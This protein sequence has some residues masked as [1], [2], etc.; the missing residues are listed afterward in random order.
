M[1]C[2]NNLFKA[3]H[4]F[5]FI[6]FLLSLTIFGCDNDK[7]IK[8]DEYILVISPSEMSFKPQKDTCNFTFTVLKDGKR[9]E[10]YFLKYAYLKFDLPDWCE[11]QYE[12]AEVGRY[13]RIVTKP[14]IEGNKRSHIAKVYYKDL[15]TTI[16]IEQS[17]ATQASFVKTESDTI[18]IGTLVKSK[19][20][21][22]KSDGAWSLDNIPDWCTIQPAQGNGNDYVTIT[23]TNRDYKKRQDATLNFIYSER[24]KLLIRLWTQEEAFVHKTTAGLEDD[25]AQRNLFGSARTLKL[26]GPLYFEDFFIFDKIVKL[27]ELDLKE[28]YISTG[29]GE[30]PSSAFSNC[31]LLKNITLPPDT[32]SIGQFAFDGCISLEKIIIPENV[33]KISAY[34]FTNCTAL[35]EIELPSTIKNIDNRAFSNSNLVEIRCK[36]VIPPK[37]NTIFTAKTYN[38]AKLIIPKDSYTKYKNDI[39]WSKFKNIIEE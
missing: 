18:D 38:E 11:F 35:K 29:L 22:I 16:N 17:G 15:T 14:N 10:N 26:K 27:E 19:G 37:L 2:K 24:K 5:L 13:L 9:A 8:E 23:I 4:F 32:Y 39:N 20:F 28:T 21:H 31:S 3:L 36:A 33:V 30:I 12:S 34:S 7:E 6:P 25:L 1:K